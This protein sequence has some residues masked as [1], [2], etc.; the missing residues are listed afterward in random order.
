MSII[1]Y[2]P[3]PSLM[4]HASYLAPRS[5][6][7]ARHPAHA[8]ARHRRLVR[9]QHRQHRPTP[10]PPMHACARSAEW[11]APEPEYCGQLRRRAFQVSRVRLCSLPRDLEFPFHPPLL[12]PSTASSLPLSY[13]LP[14]SSPRYPFHSS[15]VHPSKRPYCCTVPID[16]P[17]RTLQAADV[18]CIFAPTSTPPGSRGRILS[19]AVKA[20]CVE[21]AGRDVGKG[22]AEAGP[23]IDGCIERATVRLPRLP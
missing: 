19:A 20:L 13:A 2:A 18:D 21:R 5:H 8:Y 9:A 4:P 22:A 15:P 10:K 11:E 17:A 23:L 6:R 16:T 12:L 1:T 14:F 3:Q 7:P